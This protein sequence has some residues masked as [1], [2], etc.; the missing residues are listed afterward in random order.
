MKLSDLQR[1]AAFHREASQRHLALAEDTTGKT[2][3]EFRSMSQRHGGW[4]DHL[5]ELIRA[6]ATL[7]ELHQS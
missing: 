6:F 7:N 5:D 1:I 4:A 3:E 2:A